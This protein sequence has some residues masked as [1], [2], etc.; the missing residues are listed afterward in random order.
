MKYGKGPFEMTIAPDEIRDA[1]TLAELAAAFGTLAAYC[2]SRAAMFR[3]EQ[4][5]DHE[6][7]KHS[8]EAAEAAY[9]R[10]AP[11][12]QWVRHCRR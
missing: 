9:K 5:N 12:A 4:M 10:L 6:A 11:S 3:Y 7:A 2:E 1:A 8:G